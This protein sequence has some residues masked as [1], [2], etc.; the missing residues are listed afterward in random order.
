M[1]LTPFASSALL[2]LIFS[3]S[4]FRVERA[5]V[6]LHTGPAGDSGEENPAAGMNRL[7]VVTGPA[8]DGIVSTTEPAVWV[9]CPSADTF[10]H[11]SIWTAPVDGDCLWVAPL[12][13]LRPV[14]QGDTF[15]IPAGALTASLS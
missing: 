11:A 6:Q 1:P 10:T 2:N 14:K 7:P 4:R 5:W 9:N 13:V 15:E 3:D 8:Q 12:P